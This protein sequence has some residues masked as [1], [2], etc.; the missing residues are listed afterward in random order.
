M[1]GAEVSYAGLRTT[2]KEEEDDSDDPESGES[3]P[4]KTEPNGE[5]R[6]SQN[7]VLRNDRDQKAPISAFQYKFQLARSGRVLVM[8][9]VSLEVCREWMQVLKNAIN[10]ENYFGDCK[11]FSTDPLV[12]VVRVLKDHNLKELTV[13]NET[14]TI[15]AHK[16]LCELVAR[17]KTLTQLVL[18]NAGLTDDFMPSTSN[19]LSL[20]EALE[21][22]D[23]SKNRIGDEGVSDLVDGLYLN[24]TLK[25]LSL[26]HNVFGDIGAVHI[27]D[28][29]KTNISLTTLNL[30]N[31]MIGE[32][33]CKALAKGLIGNN[34][35]I[36]LEL[37]R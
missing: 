20:N 29:L 8:A 7:V 27:S 18:R 2:S 26:A 16:A 21:S 10:V 23:L 28:V 13:E 12:G 30:E 24:I 25:S 22:V 34:L 36:E 1:E 3:T 35:L 4:T 37:G 19:A 5:P 9:A 11:R 14:L 33:G 17:N 15:G 32:E 6:K 31:N